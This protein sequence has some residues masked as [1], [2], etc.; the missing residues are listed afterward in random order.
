MNI[1]ILGGGLSGAA[2]QRFLAQPSEVLEAEATPGGLCRTF[3]K[4]G[5]GYDIGGHILFSKNQEINELVDG[6]LGDNINRCR[7]ANQVLFNGRYVKYPFENDLAA[8]DKEDCYDCLIG[9][10]QAD[11]PKPANFEEWMY[12][13]FGRGIAEKYLLPYNRKIWKTEP[14]EWASS[15]SS[16]FPSRP[17][18][19]WSSRPWEFATEG[20]THQLFFRY[21][22][23]GGIESLVGAII[24]PGREDFTRFPRAADSP[25]RKRLAGFRRPQTPHVRRNR[26][27]VS[28]PRGRAVFRRRARGSSGGG[29]R[30][31]LQ[32]H[33]HRRC[34]PSTMRR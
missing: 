4:D 28:H 33:L 17:W 24:G 15:G 1:G 21:P 27:G 30:P 6:L 16:G 2:L 19:T 8:L 25:G 9:F 11:F 13:T 7:R 29:G 12:Y 26:G 10:L 5:F 20:Y 3:W 22:L 18:K 31:A 14:R 34:W 23:H 32:R